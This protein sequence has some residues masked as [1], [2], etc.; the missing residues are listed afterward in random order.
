MD[1]ACFK[2]K[3]KM[4]RITILLKVPF[5][6]SKFG[7]VKVKGVKFEKDIIIHTDG[8]VTKRDKKKSKALKPN[9]GHTPLSEYELAVLSKEKPEVVYIGTGHQASLPI[10]PEA[11]RI[12]KKFETIILP[13]PDVIDKIDQEHRR[14]V[15]I[16][17]VTC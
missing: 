12:L 5:L 13:T 17:H 14:L 7:W 10:T 1:Q 4:P 9:Y 8:T 16:I 11:L 15:A 6:K 2:H 3:S